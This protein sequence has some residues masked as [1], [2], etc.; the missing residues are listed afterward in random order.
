M[1]VSYW[2]RRMDWCKIHQVPSANLFF[3][4]CSA[5][6]VRKNLLLKEVLEKYYGVLKKYETNS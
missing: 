2:Y 6:G 5:F 4:K 1:K 3:W